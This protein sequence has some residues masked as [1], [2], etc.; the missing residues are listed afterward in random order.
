MFGKGRP[1][2]EQHFSKTERCYGFWKDSDNEWEELDAAVTEKYSYY[3]P[4][5]R[6]I[7]GTQTTSIGLSTD[8]DDK[9]VETG[10]KFTVK[11]SAQSLGAVL[12]DFIQ[13]VHDAITLGSPTTQTMNPATQA[14]LQALKTRCE[15]LLEK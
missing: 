15:A 2:L 11:N 12:A 1:F 7:Q 10:E 14:A 8:K 13:A 3:A 5:T 4:I 9:P 6:D